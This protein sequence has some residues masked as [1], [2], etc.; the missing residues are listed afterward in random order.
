MVNYW[1]FIVKDHVHMGRVIPAREVLA[2]RVRNKFWSLSARAR[3]L[4][5]L[6]KGDKVLFYIT[7]SRERGFMG[8]G[9]L[10]GLPHPITEEQRFHVIGEPSIGFDYAV[11]F[12][13]AEI[14]DQVI[15]LNQVK[16]KMPLLRRMRNPSRA[17]RGAIR[18][19]TEEDYEAVVQAYK[20]SGKGLAEPP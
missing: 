5:K 14:W 6:E 1:I 9:I 16:D 20:G 2:D 3:N 15:T 10:A 4:K 8:R 17:F 7:E 19:I 11:D 18:R 12:E 13:E